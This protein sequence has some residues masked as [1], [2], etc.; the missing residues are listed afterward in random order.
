MR[1][2]PLGPLIYLNYL[3]NS[4]PMPAWPLAFLAN[5]YRMSNKEVQWARPKKTKASEEA[6]LAGLD[7][8][9]ESDAFEHMF[10]TLSSSLQLL[11]V[12]HNRHR[13]L[14]ALIFYI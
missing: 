12:H 3:W 5:L 10:K 2:D 4:N 1:W 8:T 14:T 6:K 11:Q 7:S 13:L 9:D